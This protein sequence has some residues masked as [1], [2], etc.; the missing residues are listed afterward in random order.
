MV[1]FCY[2]LLL[3]LFFSSTRGKCW[4]R[5]STGGR[6]NPVR[7]CLCLCV[8]VCVCVLRICVTSR[9]RSECATSEFTGGRVVGRRASLA[10][11]T[12]M[13]LHRFHRARTRDLLWAASLSA[14][15]REPADTAK[16]V[17][18]A[19]TCVHARCR[20]ETPVRV[21]VAKTPITTPHPQP[22]DPYTHPYAA[23]VRLA[24][25]DDDQ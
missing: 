13:G 12:P 1:L 7:V 2:F 24:A 17:V 21:A 10:H 3:L 20:N 25:D 8:C 6:A 22:T 23:D 9:G 18:R 16:H 15:A 5:A 11:L 14:R 19:R 4:R